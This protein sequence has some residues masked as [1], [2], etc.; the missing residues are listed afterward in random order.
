M[1]DTADAVVAG[2]KVEIAKM[3][4]GDFGRSLRY[5]SAGHKAHFRGQGLRRQGVAKGCHA[6][7]LMAVA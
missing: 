1:G 4:V 5:G 7:W 2:L 3:K 6:W